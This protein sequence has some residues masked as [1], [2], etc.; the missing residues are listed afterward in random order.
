M[1]GL[2]LNVVAEI[3]EEDL[4]G[5]TV[6]KGIDLFVLD[7]VSYRKIS[8]DLVK[9]LRAKISSLKIIFI[10]D[11]ISWEILS[12]YRA[13]ISGSILRGDSLEIISAAFQTVLNGEIYVP[14]AIIVNLICEGHLFYNIPDLVKLLSAK[15][16]KVIN[17]LCKGQ[18]MK[19]VA[20]E[21]AMAPSTLYTHKLRISQ[22]L[23]LLS[24]TDFSS[25][26]TAY[27]NWNKNSQPN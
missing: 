7:T 6:E 21:L 14:H 1:S 24:D 20:Q 10:Y 25:F 11:I 19:E 12:A 26:L 3:E 16:I 22:K 5:L 13:G 4:L 27:E 17:Q 18:R 15:E 23:N 8:T 9:K 2:S